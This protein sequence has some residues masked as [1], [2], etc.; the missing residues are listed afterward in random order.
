MDKN[1]V[2]SFNPYIRN[3]VDSLSLYHLIVNNSSDNLGVIDVFKYYSNTNLFL[4]NWIEDLP[5]KKAG[6]LQSILF[7]A[8]QSIIRFSNRKLIWIMH[9][10][11]SHGNNRKWIKKLLF[12]R[13]IKYSDLIITHSQEGKHFIN[14]EFPKYASKVKY[15]IHPV[16]EPFAIS[17][18]RIEYDVLVWGTIHPY[19]GVLEFLEHLNNKLKKDNRIKIILLGYCPDKELL[20]SIKNHLNDNII[21]INRYLDLNEIARYAAKSRVILF[22]YNSDSVLS[23]GSLMDSIEMG[24]KIIGPN[25][26]AFR[27]LSDYKFIDT[28]NSYSEAIDLIRKNINDDID[29]LNKTE[30]EEFCKANSWKIFSL[31]LANEL[32]NLD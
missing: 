29:V 30:I 25:K 32:N 4:F 26:G 7:I 17:R 6:F 11:Y 8:F 5:D 18:K 15:Y 10:K 2:I 14:R 13:M 28:Y 19:K 1:K 9:N 20:S 23:S 24:R 3:L 12:K 21:H 27:D 22:T 31:N 16:K